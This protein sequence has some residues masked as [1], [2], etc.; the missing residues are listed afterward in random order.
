MPSKNPK[1]VYVSLDFGSGISD[2]GYWNGRKE[3]T[4]A[5][6][7][8]RWLG[9]QHLTSDASATDIPRSYWNDKMYY[10]GTDAVEA[11]RAGAGSNRL[12]SPIGISDRYGGDMH[13]QFAGVMLHRLEVKPTD[14]L[15]MIFTIPPHYLATKNSEDEILARYHEAFSDIYYAGD[16]HTNVKHWKPNTIMLAPESMSIAYTYG[17]DK[18]LKPSPL[19]SIMKGQV[20]VV[21]VGFHTIDTNV[22]VNGKPT[23]EA[24]A[25]ATSFRQG[26]YFT[27]VRPIL[28]EL[29]RQNTMITGWDVERAIRLGVE[30][31]AFDIGGYEYDITQHVEYQ[32]Q[33]LAHAFFNEFQSEHGDLAQFNKII[34]GG[35]RPG[36]LYQALS[37]IGYPM[38]KFHLYDMKDVPSHKANVI[39][40]LR[41][42]R[43]KA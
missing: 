12:E 5:I 8:V 19:I 28:A 40:A 1:D 3:L 11:A 22:V 4:D 25:R 38:D 33:E 32:M 42:L 15:H 27:V 20:A 24:Y 14:T 36:L 29:N 26:I 35:G 6:P 18:K 16:D 10:V 41:Y 34:L 37:T 43:L 39:G 31:F 23:R 17:V 30:K 13:Q 21:D 9:A 7:T 2:V